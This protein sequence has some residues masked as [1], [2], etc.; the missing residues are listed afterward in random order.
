MYRGVVSVSHRKTNTNI[1]YM[2]LRS[3]SAYVYDTIPA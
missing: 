3:T 2:T 1:L